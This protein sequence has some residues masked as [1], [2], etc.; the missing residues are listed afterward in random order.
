[1]SKVNLSEGDLA[2]FL[3][4]PAALHGE[5]SLV[6]SPLRSQMKATL[7]EKRNPLF[8]GAE[9][10]HLV[11]RREDR[12]VGRIVCHVHHEA[13][14]VLGTKDASFG[15]FECVDDVEVARA[16][17]LEAERYART[18]RCTRLVGSLNLT[19]A[20]ESGV[21]IEGFNR[22]PFVGH[23]YNPPHIPRLLEACG[24]EATQR[25]TNH[26]LRDLQ[27]FDT[28]ATVARNAAAMA[29]LHARDDVVKDGVS[30]QQARAV[31]LLF[32]FSRANIC[33]PLYLF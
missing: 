10:E 17:L 7:D 5:E 14:R 32:I 28:E 3:D 9:R 31:V 8:R 11:A 13:N 22:P 18:H 27:A 2:A 20:Q 4:V 30:R 6:V 16:L 15:F 29:A 25:M 21:L 1:M 19:A 12:L 33:A 24:Y 23:V 26:L